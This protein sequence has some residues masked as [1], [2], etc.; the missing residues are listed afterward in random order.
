M[1][2][3]RLY[4][5]PPLS[6]SMSV[7]VAVPDGIERDPEGRAVAHG[8]IRAAAGSCTSSTRRPQCAASSASAQILA[9]SSARRAARL[10]ARRQAAQRSAPSGGAARRAPRDRRE[11]DRGT[12]QPM[13]PVVGELGL[14][15]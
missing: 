5:R 10:G 11:L 15:A 7:N 9:S 13:R 1:K 6:A 14:A 8:E 12:V 4:E 3:Q 2:S